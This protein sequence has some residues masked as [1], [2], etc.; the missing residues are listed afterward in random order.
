[1]ENV[2]VWGTPDFKSNSPTVA[3]TGMFHKI[4]SV[5]KKKIT[6]RHDMSSSYLSILCWYAFLLLF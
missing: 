4:H 6:N 2:E 3:A 5:G 1:M